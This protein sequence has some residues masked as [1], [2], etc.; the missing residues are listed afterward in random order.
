M[1]LTSFYWCFLNALELTYSRTLIKGSFN[2]VPD[3]M[4]SGKPLIHLESL[5]PRG[6][7]EKSRLIGRPMSRESIFPSTSSSY[8]QTT[9]GW[10]PWSDKPE[11][12]PRLSMGKPVHLAHRLSASEPEPSSPTAPPPRAECPHWHAPSV[13]SWWTGHFFFF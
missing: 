6:L 2:C 5:L 3:F 4:Q 13:Q 8:L 1:R 10:G 11:L 7:K 9:C 12:S